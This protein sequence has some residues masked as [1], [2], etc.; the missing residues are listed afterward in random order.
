MPAV[1]GRLARSLKRLLKN[2]EASAKLAGIAEGSREVELGAPMPQRRQPGARGMPPGAHVTS[3]ELRTLRR[4]PE[5]CGGASAGA[6]VRRTNMVFLEFG[7]LMCDGACR[8][9]R[10]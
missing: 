8:A 3:G 1:R 6:W 2:V 10:Y 7:R 9:D 4:H 5:E